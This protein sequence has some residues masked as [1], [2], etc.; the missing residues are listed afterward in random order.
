VALVTPCFVFIHV[1]RTGGTSARSAIMA[2]F[3]DAMYSDG[4]PA[5]SPWPLDGCGDRITVL[6]TLTFDQK[7]LRDSQ[8]RHLNAKHSMPLRVLLIAKIRSRSRSPF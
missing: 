1:P 6:L 5:D 3:P 2:R 8:N 7:G 4:S